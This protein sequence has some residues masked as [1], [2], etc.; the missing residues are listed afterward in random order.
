MDIALDVLV[1]LD[2]EHREVSGPPLAFIDDG[3]SELLVEDDRCFAVVGGE[4][5]VV[6]PAYGYG[7]PPAGDG[8]ATGGG[9][10]AAPWP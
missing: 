1:D 10:L 7:A 5:N 4:R 6:K 3:E 8:T 2:G 9:L